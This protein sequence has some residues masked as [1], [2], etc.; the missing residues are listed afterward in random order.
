V[1]PQDSP[2]LVPHNTFAAL[3]SP[4]PRSDRDDASTDDEE[5]NDDPETDEGSEES[6]DETSEDASSE[7]E[8]PAIRPNQNHRPMP[9]VTIS[10][11]PPSGSASDSPQ[12]AKPK[13][14]GDAGK[15]KT[16]RDAKRYEQ[17]L[18][19]GGFA[20]GSPE[21]SPMGTPKPSNPSKPKGK[22]QNPK[23]KERDMTPD[24]Y[25]ARSP[26]EPLWPEESR[27]ERREQAKQ[28]KKQAKK[29]R[30]ATTRQV[31]DRPGVGGGLLADDPLVRQPEP[32][33]SRLETDFLLSRSLDFCGSSVRQL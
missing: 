20:V 17:K 16:T 29:D 2:I 13:K 11:P 23:L 5:S 6:A 4:N 32:N 25:P 21:E 9:A 19:R 33:Q 22:R 1:S 18:K 10:S 14:F 7:D 26:G 12:A 27:R 24:E 28:A 8:G 31:F 15:R 3:R 30:R